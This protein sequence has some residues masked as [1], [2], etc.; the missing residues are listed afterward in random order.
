VVDLGVEEGFSVRRKV[1]RGGGALAVWRWEVGEGRK[2]MG[3]IDGEPTSYA[4][5][6][7]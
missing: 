7:G 5:S 1:S 2:V 6:E 3:A 4:S